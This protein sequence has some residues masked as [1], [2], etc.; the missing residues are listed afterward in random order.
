ME[1]RVQGNKCVLCMFRFINLFL[2]VIGLGV[3]AAGIYVCADDSSFNWYNGSFTGLGLGI[4]IVSIIGHKS[5]FSQGGMTFYC[6]LLLITTLAMIGFTIGIIVYS[7][8]KNSIGE[9]NANAVRY[10][11]VGAC[12]VMIATFVMGLWYRN[13]IKWANFYNDHDPKRKLINM[14]EVTP[15]TDKRREEMNSKYAQLRNK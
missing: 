6:L 5:R 3:I 8:F 11:L 2:I 9:S 10:S 14:P 4:I 15:K 1:E 12:A 7:D 13:S